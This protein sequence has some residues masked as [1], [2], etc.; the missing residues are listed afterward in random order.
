MYQQFGYTPI[1]KNS[2]FSFLSKI[3]WSKILNGTQK[4]INFVNQAIPLYFNIKPIYN[5]FKTIKKI[6]KSLKNNNSWEQ[7]NSNNDLNK[8]KHSSVNNPT[9]FI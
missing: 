3:K 7:S 2:I 6:G 5:N 1:F 8:T 9:F 4:T